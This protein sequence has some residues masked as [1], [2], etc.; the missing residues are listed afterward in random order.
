MPQIHAKAD[1]I[2]LTVAAQPGGKLRGFGVNV[3]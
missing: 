3:G 2:T 1:N